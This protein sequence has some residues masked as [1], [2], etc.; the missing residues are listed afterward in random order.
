MKRPTMGLFF[1]YRPIF[2][3]F[4]AV[5]PDAFFIFPPLCAVFIDA[6]AVVFFL[7]LNRFFLCGQG[8]FDIIRFDFA[9]VFVIKLVKGRGRKKR[10]YPT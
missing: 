1:P 10:T 7:G 2:P 9:L 8:F 6:D 5:P 4:F 3:A